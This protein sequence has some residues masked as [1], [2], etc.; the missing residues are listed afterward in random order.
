MALLIPLGALITDAQRRR[1]ESWHW[2]SGAL[3]P[4]LGGC[5]YAFFLGGDRFEPGLFDVIILA[6]LIFLL[7]VYLKNPGVYGVRT[8]NKIP[9]SD[10]A[11]PWRSI[12]VG[13]VVFLSALFLWWIAGRV[14]FEPSERKLE[15]WV[16]VGRVNNFVIGR[17]CR[18]DPELEYQANRL[19]SL[20]LEWNPARIK[21]VGGGDTIRIAK[22]TREFVGNNAGLAHYRAECVQRWLVRNEHFAGVE[23]QTDGDAPSRLDDADP[24]DRAVIVWVVPKGETMVNK[25]DG[26][27]S[28]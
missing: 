4:P 16:L 20:L 8:L 23:F 2:R 21:L 1:S 13:A 17:P 14:R 3:L 6:A 12:R 7:A 18:T 10:L 27:A 9:K 28:K 24:V 5:L 26:P 15:K 11:E 22:L 25:R 19:D